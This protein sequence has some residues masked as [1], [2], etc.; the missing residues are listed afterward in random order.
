MPLFLP[1]PQPLPQPLPP[2]HDD[3]LEARDSL[4]HELVRR[5][6]LCGAFDND[7]CRFL[8]WCW[9]DGIRMRAL[10]GLLE[11]MEPVG[12]ETRQRLAKRFMLIMMAM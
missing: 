5:L 10:L 8:L 3:S 2:P 12:F 1:Q 4:R 7:T 11:S 6:G 9:N